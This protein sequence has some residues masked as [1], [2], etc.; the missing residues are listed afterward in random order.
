[1]LIKN[2]KN[3]N[4]TIVFDAKPKFFTDRTP[5][6]N[7]ECKTRPHANGGWRKRSDDCK[8]ETRGS[9]H[10]RKQEKGTQ[11]SNYCYSA[12]EKPFV[13]ENTLVEMKGDDALHA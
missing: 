2:I 1:M 13:A 6:T 8:M 9:T 4:P 7:L 5:P 12:K 3:S 10:R 11:Q